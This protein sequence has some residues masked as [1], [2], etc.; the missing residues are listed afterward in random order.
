MSLHSTIVISSGTA[1]TKWP[2][3]Q[4]FIVPPPHVAGKLCY[5]KLAGL[6]IPADTNYTYLEITLSWSQPLTVDVRTGSTS[7][8]TAIISGYPTWND[9]TPVLC[10]IPEGPH[11]LSTSIL[12]AS[13]KVTSSSTSGVT[14]LLLDIEP[15]RS[16]NNNVDI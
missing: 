12:D 16:N 6:S 9:A 3:F 2:S 15:L 11:V 1:S 5:V 4:S 8:T 10:F 13:G 7:S 14:T